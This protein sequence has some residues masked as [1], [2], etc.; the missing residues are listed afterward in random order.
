MIRVIGN[1]A[2]AL[3]SVNYFA[4]LATLGSTL[5]LLVIPDIGF[6]MPASSREWILLILL[7]V[8][9]FILQFLLTAGLQLDRTSK[10]TSMLYT[11]ILFA[12][13]F[14]WGIWGV[15]PGI[16][17][18]VGGGIVVVST[19]WS[20]VQKVEAVAEKKSVGIDEESALLG[21]E[22]QGVDE[23]GQRRDGTRS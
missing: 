4:L 15:V 19:F 8:L 22:T 9:G 20:A 13:A 7:G 6:V 1:R 18:L 5:A 23:V 14:D 2:H 10:A 12:L 3:M 11:Q 17:S 16:W 21:A